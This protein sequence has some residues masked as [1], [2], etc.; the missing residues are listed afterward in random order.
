MNNNSTC[1]DF[2]ELYLTDQMV[3]LIV[4]EANRHADQYLDSNLSNTYLDEWQPVTSPEI[5]TLIGRLLLMD[6]IYK[7]QLPMYWSNDVLYNTLIFSEVINRKQILVTTD[8]RKQ[9]FHFSKN[10]YPNYNPNDENRDRLQVRLFIDL[11]HIQFR[12]VYSPG[13][14]S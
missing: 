10:E 1:L 8:F 13:K 7:S 5:K 3:E 11:M 4:T 9:I 2:L 12:V 14:S 6:I